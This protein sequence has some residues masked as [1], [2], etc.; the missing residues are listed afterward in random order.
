[1]GKTKF[2]LFATLI[3]A[4]FNVILNVTLIPYF[5]I[6]GAALASLAA[7]WMIH[8]FY[9]IKL[10]QISKLHP[11]TR[12]YIKTITIAIVLLAFIYVLSIFIKIDFWMLPLILFF[13]LCSY[14]LLLFI[15]KCIDKEDIE[16]LLTVEKKSGLN[17]GFI[18]KI[19]LR[20]I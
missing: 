15:T 2:I 12:N 6:I 3:G 9:S 16:F 11:F 19:L 10:Y 20:F 13:F 4:I 14:G 17:L 8:I 18:K 1:M 7:Y 5:G